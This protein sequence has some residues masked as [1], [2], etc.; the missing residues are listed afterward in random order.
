MFSSG[1]RLNV[2]CCILRRMV[3]FYALAD[4]VK[5]LT[6]CRGCPEIVKVTYINIQ[7]YS[8]YSFHLSKKK[9]K[10]VWVYLAFNPD[11]KEGYKFD[12]N[13]CLCHRS[14][15]NKWSN[16]NFFLFKHYPAV[17]AVVVAVWRSLPHKRNYCNNI[18]VFIR[19]R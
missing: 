10:N 1:Y 7:R 17:V 13:V 12:V 19:N 9:L 8:Y 2:L 4:W 18:Y 16:F 6:V 14:S 15:W 11:G 3:F 5:M